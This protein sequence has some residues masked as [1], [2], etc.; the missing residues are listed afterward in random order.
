MLSFDY[1]S[2]PFSSVLYIFTYD[3]SILIQHNFTLTKAPRFYVLRMKFS[4]WLFFISPSSAK[5]HLCDTEYS[6]F[7]HIY[8]NVCLQRC[9]LRGLPMDVSQAVQPAVRTDLVHLFPASLLPPPTA[10]S[11]HGRYYRTQCCAFCSSQVF[12]LFGVISFL[13]EVHQPYLIYLVMI[14]SWHYCCCCIIHAPQSGG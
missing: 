1:S 2:R 12:V 13:F 10:P 4:H 9:L 7:T 3:T 5:I 14:G 11:L 8:V 6:V